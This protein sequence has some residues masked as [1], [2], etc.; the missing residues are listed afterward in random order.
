MTATITSRHFPRSAGG[1]VGE[2]ITEDSIH[3][4]NRS[5]AERGIEAGQITL[6]P[7]DAV[8]CARRLNDCN[9]ELADPWVLGPSPRMTFGAARRLS[10]QRYPGVACAARVF[11]AL[12]VCLPMR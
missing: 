11:Q 8:V 5:L 3:A 9:Y 12:S 2:F 6:A 7:T 1:A 10:I 4:L